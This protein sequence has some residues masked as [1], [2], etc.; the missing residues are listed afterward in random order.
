MPDLD[1]R[2]SGTQARRKY[3]AGTNVG[4]VSAIQGGSGAILNNFLFID[5]ILI[6]IDGLEIGMG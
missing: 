5:T 3:A 1:L 6:T 2:V 4:S